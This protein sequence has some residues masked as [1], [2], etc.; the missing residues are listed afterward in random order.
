MW[1]Q[2]KMGKC[3]IKIMCF[4][5]PAKAGIQIK[6]SILD[7]CLRRNDDREKRQ[8]FDFIFLSFFFLLTLTA[9][10]FTPVYQK[11]GT[12]K[13]L[14]AITIDTPRT[15]EGQ[16]LKAALEDTLAPSGTAAS[17]LYRLTPNFGIALEPLSI[18]SDGTTRRY[19][20]IGTSNLTLTEIATGKAVFSDQVQ[21]FSSY[22]ISDADYSTYVAG[23]DATRQL[24]EAMAEDIRLR[25]VN[26]TAKQEK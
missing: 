17:P 13:T 26:F 21:R 2:R 7:S 8:F 3:N 23:K 1:W 18:E 16:L 24:V 12:G 22:H 5:I 10:G 6:Q 20:M 25:L 15:R 11:G 19:R 4:V 14:A 9:C